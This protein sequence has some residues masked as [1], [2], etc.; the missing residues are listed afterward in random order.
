MRFKHH[1]GAVHDEWCHCGG[2]YRSSGTIRWFKCDSG[3][4][5]DE[6]CHFD[7]LY[8]S[9]GVIW[10]FKPCL[11]LLS[12]PT[13][14][15]PLY[16]V[17]EPAIQSQVYYS[18]PLANCNFNCSR[19][20]AMWTTLTNVLKTK[21][22]KIQP[23]VLWKTKT[24]WNYCEL[25]RPCVQCVFSMYFVPLILHINICSLTCA[26]VTLLLQIASVLS[27]NCTHVW[28]RLFV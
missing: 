12:E 2:S 4:V 23:L 15:K 5:H 21:I 1:S 22:Y 19:I 3:V 26:A 9:S 24:Q 11:K 25:L 13:T 17:N 18:L 28:C 20:A 16:C 14:V 8:H 10:D 27:V 6:W 7:G